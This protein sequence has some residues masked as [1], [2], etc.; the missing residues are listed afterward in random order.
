ML[1]RVSGFR[2]SNTKEDHMKLP[3]LFLFALLISLSACG[4]AKSIQGKWEADVAMKNSGPG[5]KIVFEFLPDGTF[6]AMPAGDTILV[7]K[8]RYELLDDGH[9]LKI[10]SQL[11][12]ADAVCKYTGDAIQCETETANINFKR[13]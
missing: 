5:V 10:R 1:I 8:E 3:I 12:G 2:K 4:G 6:N 13:L 9:T 7:D 11:I